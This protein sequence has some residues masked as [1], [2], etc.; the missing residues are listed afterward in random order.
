MST[1]GN[2]NLAAV[3][4]NGKNDYQALELPVGEKWEIWESRSFQFQSGA[5]DHIEYHF[6]DDWKHVDVQTV[7]TE[8]AAR[9]A[10]YHAGTG[11][12]Q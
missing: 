1:Y 8:L 12:S 5:L 11:G 3:Q 9:Q 4:R 6:G 10:E 2:E 7:T